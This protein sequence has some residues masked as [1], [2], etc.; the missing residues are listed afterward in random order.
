MA[1]KKTGK[2]LKYFMENGI[3]LTLLIIV[4]ILLIIGIVYSQRGC[5]RGSRGSN[6]EFFDANSSDPCF[7]LFYAPWCGHCKN[8]MPHWGKLEA[9]EVAN[10]NN[11]VVK[12]I[13]INSDENKELIATHGVQGFP[14]IKYFPNGINGGNAIDFNGDRDLRGLTSFI[15]QQ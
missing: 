3:S 13:K 2:A 9:S 11:K 6:F 5:N 10:S 1:K 15:G 7:V 8:I 12:I 4:I 14:T